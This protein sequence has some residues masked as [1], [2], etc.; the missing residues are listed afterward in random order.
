VCQWLFENVAGIAPSPARPGFDE[1]IVSPN[2]LPAL[3][4]VKA[5]HDCR[6]GRVEA[7][8]TLKG[9]TA[10]YILTVPEGAV[11]SV[12]P[13][14]GIELISVDG[15]KSAAK[16]PKLSAGTHELVFRMARAAKSSTRRKTK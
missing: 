9:D 13:E 3:S 15:R 1:I 10:R 5:W 7:A 6:H 16:P 11:A 2:F 14:H 4:P 12:R 8:W